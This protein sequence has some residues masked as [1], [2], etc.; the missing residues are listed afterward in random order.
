MFSFFIKPAGPRGHKRTGSHGNTPFKPSD[1]VDLAMTHSQTV[2]ADLNHT[3]TAATAQIGGYRPSMTTGNWSP[4]SP[5]LP[6][7]IS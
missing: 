4:A 3:P 7:P 1:A 6:A 2:P 5:N